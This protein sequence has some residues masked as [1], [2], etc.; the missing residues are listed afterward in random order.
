MS[1]RCSALSRSSYPSPTRPSAHPG[2]D[3]ADRQK[4]RRDD[5]VVTRQRAFGARGRLG[6]QALRVA[7]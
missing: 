7:A 6:A 3:E 4:N 5:F 2:A 1:W